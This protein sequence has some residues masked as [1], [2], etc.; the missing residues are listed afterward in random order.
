MTFGIYTLGSDNWYLHT[1]YLH[2]VST[3]SVVTVSTLDLRRKPYIPISEYAMG[4]TTE[5]SE[6]DSRPYKQ[7]L[8]QSVQTDCTAHTASYLEHVGPVSGGDEF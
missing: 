7:C 2:L 1:G 8:P 5:G 4:W 3:H 6:L